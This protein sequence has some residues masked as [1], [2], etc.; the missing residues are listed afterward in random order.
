VVG[1]GSDPRDEEAALAP[2]T[3]Y[4]FTKAAA[5]R[6]C[7]CSGLP[8][9]ICR[10]VNIV[11]S[12]PDP[13]KFPSICRQIIFSGKI[14]TIYEGSRMYIHARDVAEAIIAVMDTPGKFNIVGKELS[15]RQVA[16]IVAKKLKK[17]LFYEMKKGGS[18]H[19]PSYN[20]SG[21]KLFKKGWT[22]KTDVEEYI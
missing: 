22:I 6:L 12:E 4:A 18:G 9:T 1:P 10:P 14:L 21:E 5:E 20:L 17:E 16:E 2:T 7:E 15:N 13:R 19:E 8:V 3:P 11:C